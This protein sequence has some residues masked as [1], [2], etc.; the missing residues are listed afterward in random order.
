MTKKGIKPKRYSYEEKMEIVMEYL[1]D[2]QSTYTFAKRYGIPRTTIKSWIES[3]NKHGTVPKLTTGDYR[4]PKSLSLE[5]Y[6]ERYEIL[7]KYRAFLKEQR[8]RK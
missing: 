2:K 8:E 4:E 5:D 7:K 6:K 1:N 3:Y